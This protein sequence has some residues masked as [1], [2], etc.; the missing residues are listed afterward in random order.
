MKHNQN[1]KQFYDS[2][3]DE[4][5]EMTGLE[6]RFS[7][8]TPVFQ[9]LLKKYHIE[10]ALD[11]GCGTGFHSI[12]LAQ[13]GLQVTAT[14]IS[15]QMLNVTQKNAKQKNVQVETIQSSFNDLN[16]KTNKTYDAVFCL[17]NS[18]A[19]ILEEKELLDSLKIF[20]EILKFGGLLFVQ[21]LNYNRIMRNRER[22]QSIKEINGNIFVRFYDFIDKILLFNV[23]TIKKQGSE[24]KHSLRSIEIFP[25][26]SA[27]LVR[28]FYDAGYSQTQLF[29]NMSLN[30]YDE[31]SSKDLVIIARR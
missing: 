13:L 20:H 29:G 14:D 2:F 5:N 8:E 15:E 7:K 4:Y 17:G 19:H 16:K 11:A 31:L 6:I 26:Q 27:D 12:L 30:A 10:L 3:A 9:S 28:I 23:L 1:P 24:I 21:M 22:I 25:W 18:L